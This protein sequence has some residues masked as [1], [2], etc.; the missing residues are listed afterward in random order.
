M[1]K[2]RKTKHYCSIIIPLYNEADGIPLLVE[3]L[4]LAL[5]NREESFELILVDDGS[6]DDTLKTLNTLH[7]NMD[8]RIISLSR[9]F[10][11]QSALLAGLHASDGQIA[12][13]MD[14]DLQHPPELIP[15]M[16]DLHS[17]GFDIVFTKR[18]E[19]EKISF[20]HFSSKAFYYII[21]RLSETKIPLNS[22]DFRSM[23]RT[24]LD[25]LL[26]MPEKNIF[27]R[28]MVSWIGFKSITLDYEAD[29]RRFGSSKF[30][31]QK[32]MLLA[33]NGLVS[34]TTKPLVISV[35]AS[36]IFFVLAALY[37]A[38]VLVVK[39]IYQEEVSGWASILFV[40]LVVSGFFSAYLS[41][42]ALYISSIYSEVKK[43]PE[44]IIKSTSKL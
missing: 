27:L 12:I 24:A 30:S 17:K 7:I 15:T 34:F 22:S 43:R 9:N 39:F 37:A 29:I 1:L 38:Y 19:Q 41:L 23:N 25:A 21:N 33:T 26:S 44:Y 6:T 35:Y 11:H 32:M 28:G 16:L 18:N 20:K 36:V 8:I 5:R 13:T 2:R 4:S 42:I 3:K 31:L 14:G 10:G 40:L